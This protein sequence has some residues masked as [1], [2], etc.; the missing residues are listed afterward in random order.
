MRFINIKM[1]QVRQACCASVSGLGEFL[2]WNFPARLFIGSVESDWF[3]N[4]PEGQGGA[5]PHPRKYRPIPTNRFILIRLWFSCFEANRKHGLFSFFCFSYLL[6]IHQTD[7]LLLYI[8]CL[9]LITVKVPLFETHLK[10]DL[11][12]LCLLGCRLQ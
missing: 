1:R 11:L 6:E 10:N 2:E 12:S 7:F 5:L 9:T 8:Y 3:S 4:R